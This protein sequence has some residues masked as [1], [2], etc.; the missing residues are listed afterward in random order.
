MSNGTK[1][2]EPV[3][4]TANKTYDAI[5]GVLG[6]MMLIIGCLQGL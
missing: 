3:E 4:P 6:Q 5:S 1:F 2:Y